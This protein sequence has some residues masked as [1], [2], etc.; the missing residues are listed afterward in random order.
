MIK[1]SLTSIFFI[2]TERVICSRDVGEGVWSNGSNTR[3]WI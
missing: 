1:M 3:D 2:K